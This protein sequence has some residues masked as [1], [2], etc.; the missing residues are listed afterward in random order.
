MFKKADKILW[1][2]TDELLTKSLG[3]AISQLN[4]KEDPVQEQYLQAAIEAAFQVIMENTE[5]A[6]KSTEAMVT[7]LLPRIGDTKTQL[8]NSQ[9]ATRN[10]IDLMDNLAGQELQDTKLNQ[11]SDQIKLLKVSLDKVISNFEESTTNLLHSSIIEPISSLQNQINKSCEVIS[12]ILLT[13]SKSVEETNDLLESEPSITE[14]DQKMALNKIITE[15]TKNMEDLS[16]RLDDTNQNIVDFVD[17]IETKKS[18][19]HTQNLQ[20]FNKIRL[21]LEDTNKKLMIAF[22]KVFDT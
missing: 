12:E 4:S 11:H 17:Q 5:I 20:Q 15:H 14:S 22:D 2:R 8:Q 3:N 16:N 13:Q 21:N 18:E 6:S 9:T 10:L 19:T 1:T 7:S